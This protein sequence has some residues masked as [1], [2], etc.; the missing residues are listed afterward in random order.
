MCT[1]HCSYTLYRVGVSGPLSVIGIIDTSI[2]DVVM[3]CVCVCV[4]V[5]LRLGVLLCV[6]SCECI[7]MLV[8]CIVCVYGRRGV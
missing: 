4:G 8:C 3:V 5:C 1:G 7:Y 6:Y 2:T